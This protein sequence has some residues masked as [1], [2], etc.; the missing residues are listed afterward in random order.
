M[1]PRRP[2]PLAR[3]R[4]N[5]GFSL[6]ELGIVLAVAAILMAGVT[7]SIQGLTRHA[8]AKRTV[9]ELSR[10]LAA[11]QNLVARTL[12]I[13]YTAP[14]PYS[15]QGTSLVQLPPAS[16]PNPYE[17]DL[18]TVTSSH[19]L[20]ETLM[21]LLG[22]AAGANDEE[23]IANQG[24]NPYGKAYKLYFNSA[25]VEVRTCVDALDH[26]DYSAFRA[27]GTCSLAGCNSPDW[28]CVSLSGP[29]VSTGGQHTR[30]SYDVSLF[31]LGL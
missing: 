9:D 16:A 11:G 29:L 17:I 30:Y 8:R 5:L 1:R 31:G 19:A 28:Q 24:K 15:L 21:D 18:S 7:M 12:A 14:N 3:F 25:R 13:D 20:H 6:I 27:L 4:R 26:F 22:A 23:T 2:L 10:L